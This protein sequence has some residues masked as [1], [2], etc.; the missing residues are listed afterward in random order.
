M[1]DHICRSLRDG[2]L[3]GEHAVALTLKDSLHSPFGSHT[4]NHFLCSLASNISSGRSQARRL[5]LMAFDR[6]PM[7]YV[8]LLTGKGLDCEGLYKWL[9]I[10]DSYSDP[11]GW[12]E[13]LKLPRPSVEESFREKNVSVFKDVRDVD[14][15]LSEILKLG[16]G[17]MG[18]VNTHFAV[19]IDSVSVLLRHATLPSVANLI[20]SIRSQD[21]VSS[22][23]WLIH[24]DLH[25]SRYIA[26]FEYISTMVASLEPKILPTGTDDE[27]TNSECLVY[28]EENFVGGKFHVRMKR[29]NGRVK[30]LHE[31]FE[32]V[33]GE[34]KFSSAT[35]ENK[36]FIQNLVPKVQFNLQLSEKE[37]ADRA[38]V[39]LP[40]EHQGT[41]ETLRIYDGRQSFLNTEKG[42][43]LPQSITS[44]SIQPELQ[45]E[46]DMGEIHYIRDSDDEFPDS[47][48]D[49]DDDLDI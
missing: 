39:V 2:S 38:K 27:I 21:K 49:P 35:I 45:S 46:S 44:T 24:S 18:D 11:L 31:Q 7:F 6:S 9:W 40:F 19:A 30:V 41:G 1:A 28:L 10:L 22:I 43:G 33:D 25:E 13:K 4:F 12:L 17:A 29:R 16:Q 48:E 3:E 32:M 23:F 26:S 34:V 15:L 14:R 42:S 8:D 47:D 5:V 37:I 36:I 20:N